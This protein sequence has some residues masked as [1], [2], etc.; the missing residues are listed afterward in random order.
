MSGNIWM[1]SY[2]IDEQDIDMLQRDFITFKQGAEYYKL[3]MKPFTR[4]CREAGAVYKI[5]KMVR[6][7]RHILEAYFRKVRKGEKN[8]K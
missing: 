6:I 4:M 8:G 2:N 5:G 3:G 7:N 1:Y